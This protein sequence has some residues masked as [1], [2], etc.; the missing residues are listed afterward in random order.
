[1]GTES[2]RITGAYG[3]VLGRIEIYSQGNRRLTGAHGEMLGRE[4]ADGRTTGSHGEVVGR[5]LLESLV[6]KAPGR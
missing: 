6:K 4:S 2:K 5:N 3:E 1:M